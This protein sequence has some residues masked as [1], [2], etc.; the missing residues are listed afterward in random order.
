MTNFEIGYISFMKLAGFVDSAS[1]AASKAMRHGA[2][3][4]AVAATGIGTAGLYKAKQ[5]SDE[6]EAQ[7]Q[8]Q[9]Q[10]AQGIT[11]EQALLMAAFGG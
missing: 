7:A 8:Y 2:T 3:V 4:P 6:G 10:A 5:K 11:P 9:Q 1:A